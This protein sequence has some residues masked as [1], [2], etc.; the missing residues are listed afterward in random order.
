MNAEIKARMED[1]SGSSATRE[2]N[3]E[4]FE[5]LDERMV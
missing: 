2:M 4:L 5:N 3:S 1:L